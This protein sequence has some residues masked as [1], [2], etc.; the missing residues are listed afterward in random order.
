MTGG[1]TAG[2][3]GGIVGG[4][5]SAGFEHAP[6]V[7]SKTPATAQKTTRFKIAYRG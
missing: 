3:A 6:A 4:V 1:D 7:N 2:A 5:S